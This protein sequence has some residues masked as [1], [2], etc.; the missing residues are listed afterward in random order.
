MRNPLQ[1]LLLFFVLIALLSSLPTPVLAD[2]GD[3][4][5]VTLPSWLQLL[6]EWLGLD[7]F[8]SS[9]LSPSTPSTPTPT[10]SATVFTPSTLTPVPG[11]SE[12]QITS[13]QQ[14]EILLKQL[15]PGQRVRV[16]A[17]ASDVQSI[18]V[19]WM[20]SP[21]ARENGLQGGTFSLQDGFIQGS[22][23]VERAFLEKQG[24]IIPFITGD[25]IEVTGE[26]GFQISDCRPLIRVQKMTMNRNGIP[27]TVLVEQML[28][29]AIAKEWPSEV[30]VESL[31]ISQKRI[32]IE[33]HR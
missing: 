23:I 22:I 25:V 9:L 30:C 20:N 19:S 15:R 5:P 13:L 18:L 31:T 10:P 26:I 16:W 2:G 7:N 4:R 3:E 29:E 14:M 28:N 21:A 33:G 27:L 1:R 32:V 11:I 17:M 12:Y 8:F 24:F 6:L